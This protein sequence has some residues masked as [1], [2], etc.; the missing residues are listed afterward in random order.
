MSVPLLYH[1]KLFNREVFSSFK[2]N[3]ILFKIQN[4]WR[5][6]KFFGNSESDSINNL[7]YDDVI[8]AFFSKKARRKEMIQACIFVCI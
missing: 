6:F 1:L 4:Q 3:Y 8:N 2:N 5:T 7:N